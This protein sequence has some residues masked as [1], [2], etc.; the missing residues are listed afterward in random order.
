MDLRHLTPLNAPVGAFA[1]AY[2][3]VSHDSENAEHEGALRWSEQRSALEQQGADAETLEAL[4]AAVRDARSAVG[5]A[6]RVLVARAGTLLLDRDL[7]EPPDPPRATWSPLPDLLPLLLDGPEPT[8]V[9]VA[10]V[11]KN[12]GEILLADPADSESYPEPVQRVEGERYPTHK[13]RGGGWKHLKMQ[14]TVE[15]T[16][17]SNV[18]ALAERIDRQVSQSGAR[19]LVLA[20]EEQSRKLLLDNLGTRAASIA[21][22]VEHSGLRSGGDD[23]AL[24]E[25][26]AEAAREVATRER[27]QVLDRFEQLTGRPDGAVAR[28]LAQV[29]AALRSEQVDTLL[30]DGNVAREDVVWI[31]E[32]PAQVALDRADLEATGAQP[33]AQVPVDAAL[34]RAAAGTGAEFYPLGGG[35][36]GLVGH[37]VPDGVAALL[38]W[39]LATGA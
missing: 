31:G 20:G 24:A 10:R 25:A 17:R 32:Q 2:L 30:I 8:T 38:R 16:W 1:T 34:L 18:S 23:D 11:D 33:L 36:T 28:G 3:D 9:V 6:G 13:V 12:G 4:D 15:N 7:P 26:V 39:P 14:H 19:V 22:E 21:T 27:H 35:R 29:L 5:R 37:P